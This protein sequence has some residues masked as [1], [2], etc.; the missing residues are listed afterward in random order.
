MMVARTEKEWEDTADESLVWEK[1]GGEWRGF[2]TFPVWEMR[3]LWR[4][5]LG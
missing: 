1:M 2:G 4:W 5:S 3:R